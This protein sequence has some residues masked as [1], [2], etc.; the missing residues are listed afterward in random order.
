[1]DTLINSFS[2][3]GARA[4]V[5]E[6]RWR[7]GLIDITNDDRGERFDLMLD[8]GSRVQVLDVQSTDR[9]LLLLIDK[10]RFLCGHDERHW[11]VAA[12]PETTRAKTVRGAKEALMPPAVRKSLAR[13]NV[14]QSNRH[15]RRNDAFV[16]QGEWFFI[17]EPEL[18]ISMQLALLNEPIRRGAGKP[19]I[20]QYVFRK[21]GVP[22]YVSS[23]APNGFKESKYR[24]WLRNHPREKVAWTVMR[25]NA[26]VFA[27]GKVRHPDHKTIRLN[28]WHRVEM[29]TETKA[30]AMRNMAFLD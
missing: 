6:R 20:V 13:H 23:V 7:D 25:R 4:Q 1:M 15:R 17:P 5:R 29:N 2:K 11:F 22:V 21:G 14:K 8:R 3:I 19:H 24:A 18:R 9:H 10:A 30:K 26:R 28:C 27:K 16:R 12:I